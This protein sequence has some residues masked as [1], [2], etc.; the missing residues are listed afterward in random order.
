MSTADRDAALAVIQSTSVPIHDI[1]TAIYLSRDV[2][3]WAGEWGWPNPFAFYFAGRGGMLGD[4]GPEVACSAFGWFEPTTLRTFFEEG[5]A[6]AAPAVA[7]QRMAEAHA[8]WGR[9]HLNQVEGIA[10]MVAVTETVVDGL[11]GSGLPL[12]AGWRAIPRADDDAGR[13]AQLMQILR[14]WRGGLHLVATTAVGLSPLEA[15]LTNEGEGQAKFFGWA[16]PYPDCG[17]ITSK[18]AEAEA[19]T[20]QLSVSSFS[21]ALDQDRFGAFEAAVSAI[22]AALP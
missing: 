3:G 22:H 5:A 2:F 8:L 19:M 13:M 4:V 15:I 12:F 10:E 20:D 18:H 11:E 16:A 14:E 21:R 6:V 1:G 9:K 17:S 7:A